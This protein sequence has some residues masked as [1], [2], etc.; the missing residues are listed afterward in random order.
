[1]NYSQ[2]FSYSY[3]VYF[4]LFKTKNCIPVYLQEILIQA[5]QQSGGSR[6]CNSREVGKASVVGKATC[7]VS[8]RHGK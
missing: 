4:S 3:L 2:T 1:M 8:K 5:W 7:K 6:Q